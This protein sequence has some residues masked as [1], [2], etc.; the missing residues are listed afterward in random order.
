MKALILAAGRG[1]RMRPLTD[2][3]PKPLLAVG[4]KPLI[5]WHLEKLRAAGVSEVVINTSWL[6]PHIH[7]ALGDGRAFGV[8]IQYSDEQPAPYETGGGIATALP[9]LSQFMS[10]EKNASGHEKGQEAFIALSAD[11]WTDLDYQV[12]TRRAQSMNTAFSSGASSANVSSTTASTALAHLWLVPNPTFHPQG[13]FSLHHGQIGRES[14]ATKPRLTF[15]NLGVYHPALF[16]NVAPRT[17][18]K[19]STLLDAAIAQQRVSGE[20]LHAQWYN[21]GTPKQLDELN[22]K[23]RHNA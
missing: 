3:T 10:A 23:L 4:G 17:H 16:A 7:A 14:S 15:A 9:L 8:K 1:E 6:A 12:L 11:I 19:L 20:M 18:V 5:V 21:L 13:D 22:Q 2:T